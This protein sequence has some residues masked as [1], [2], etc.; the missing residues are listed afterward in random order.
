MVKFGLQLP[1]VIFSGKS[2]TDLREHE[3]VLYSLIS[4]VAG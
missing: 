1:I 4:G 2:L 3:G